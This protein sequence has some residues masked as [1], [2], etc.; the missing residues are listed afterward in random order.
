[1][2]FP[3]SKYIYIYVSC[4]VRPIAPSRDRFHADV[5]GILTG[6]PRGKPRNE[7][8]T[9]FSAFVLQEVALG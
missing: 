9:D 1:M 2:V 6:I 8:V 3:T 5:A 7:G 4:V